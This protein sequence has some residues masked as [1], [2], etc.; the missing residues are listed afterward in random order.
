MLAKKQMVA[1]EQENM[2]VEKEDKTQRYIR[3][4]I[5]VKKLLILLMLP[6][7]VD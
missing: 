3:L 1:T 4:N 6:T 5:S 7:L 2:Q